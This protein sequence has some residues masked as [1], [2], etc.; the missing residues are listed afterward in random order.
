MG[1]AGEV[2]SAHVM[3]ATGDARNDVVGLRSPG[4]R[5]VSRGD[6]VAAAV[7]FWGGLSARAGL[8]ADH[9]DAFLKAAIAYFGGLSPG[10][11]RRTLASQAE[12]VFEAVAHRACAGRPA[13]GAQSGTSTGHD[14]WIHTPIREGSAERI[15]SGMPFQVD[16]IPTP[17][18]TGWAL[19]CEDGVVFADPLRSGQSLRALTSSRFRANRG[20][21]QV[22]SR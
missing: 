10:T 14:E 3:Y 4:G 11:R 13:L 2:L 7:G 16:I 15:A 20:A 18:R 12:A 6:G 8:V 19:N 21:P 22:R 17:L 1:Y 5:I 9:D